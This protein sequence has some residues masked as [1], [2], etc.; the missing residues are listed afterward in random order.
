MAENGQRS[1][2]EVFQDAVG[3]VQEIVRA[4]IRLAKVELRNEAG[5][6]KDAGI[7]LGGAAAIGLFSGALLVVAGVCALA[8]IMPFWGAALVMAALCGI[9][10]GAMAAA[11][12]VRLKTMHGPQ[13]TLATVAEDMTWARNQTR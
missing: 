11:G 4:E 7:M 12:R 1:L 9:V 6:A 5:K 3:H 2:G 8:I 13:Q 10:A